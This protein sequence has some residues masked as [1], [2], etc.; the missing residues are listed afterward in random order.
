MDQLVISTPNFKLKLDHNE[1]RSIRPLPVPREKNHSIS[2]PL[3]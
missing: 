3:I 1:Y 2:F